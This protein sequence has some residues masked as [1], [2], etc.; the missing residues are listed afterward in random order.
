MSNLFFERFHVLF[1]QMLCQLLE[2]VSDCL[3]SFL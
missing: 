3:F 1:H 2:L